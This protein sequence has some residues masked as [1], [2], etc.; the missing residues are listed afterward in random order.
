MGRADLIGNG[1]KCLIPA[2]Q[3]LGTTENQAGNKAAGRPSAR[4]AFAGKRMESKK[5]EPKKP[6]RR[7]R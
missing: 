4:P 1:K 2:W 7:P 3:P 6:F 5:A